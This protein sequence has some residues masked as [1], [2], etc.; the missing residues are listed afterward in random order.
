MCWRGLV[1]WF[2]FDPDGRAGDGLAPDEVATHDV[3]AELGGVHAAAA[4]PLHR[5]A[6]LEQPLQHLRQRSEVSSGIA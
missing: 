2:L 6:L 1:Q 4:R 5:E 3:L